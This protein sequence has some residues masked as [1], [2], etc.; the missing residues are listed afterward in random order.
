MYAAICVASIFNLLWCFLLLLLLLFVVRMFPSPHLHV[1][2]KRVR[3]SRRGG[4]RSRNAAGTSQRVDILMICIYSPLDINPHVLVLDRVASSPHS[5]CCMLR[6]WRR[7]RR[8]RLR[9][10]DGDV[11]KEGRLGGRGGGGGVEGSTG[12]ENNKQGF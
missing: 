10:V 7:Q 6:C 12:K 5:T 8:P 9:G 4:L 11:R 2:T 3:C 1:Y